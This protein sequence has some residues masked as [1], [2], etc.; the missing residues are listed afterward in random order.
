MIK[1]HRDAMRKREGK[2]EYR[3]AVTRY[4]EYGDGMYARHLGVVWL[5][6][7]HGEDEA[8]EIFS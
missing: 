5:D 1:A 8:V 4:I 3:Y 2:K 6:D 7:P